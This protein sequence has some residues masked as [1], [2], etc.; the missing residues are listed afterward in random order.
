M[1]QPT[2]RRDMMLA[3]LAAS[4][5]AGFLESLDDAEGPAIAGVRQHLALQPVVV[6]PAMPG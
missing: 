2:F 3:A 4:L 6:G 1:N 5:P